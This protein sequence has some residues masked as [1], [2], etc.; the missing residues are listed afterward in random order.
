MRKGLISVIVPVYNGASYLKETLDSALNQTYSNIEIIVVDD[1]S[2]DAS[3]S[4]VSS[5]GDRMTYIRQDNAGPA[6]A[7]NSGVLHSNGEYLAFLDQDDIWDND[8]LEKQFVLLEAHADAVGVYCDHRS[9]DSYGRIIGSTGAEGHMRASGQILDVLIDGNFILTASLIL[10]RRNFYESTGGFDVDNP[11]W[12]D[13][14]DLWMR[15]A[16]LGPFLYQIDTLVSYRRHD[17]N[18]SGSDYE[19]LSGNVCALKNVEK[20]I[21]HSA[22]SS[23]LDKIKTSIY[24]ASLGKAWHLR[25]LGSPIAALKAY[26]ECLGLKPLRPI[27]WQGMVCSVLMIFFIAFTLRWRRD[28]NNN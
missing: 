4:I 21:M 24:M 18:T 1:G 15:A 28:N 9:I 12:S 17:Q 22:R 5:C 13:D 2:H 7:R 26:V 10:L 23:T 27:V 20:F 25:R 6:S 16:S 14:Y 3:P 11:F 8:K 19:M